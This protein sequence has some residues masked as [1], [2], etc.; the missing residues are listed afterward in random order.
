MSFDRAGPW[1]FYT[2]WEVSSPFLR[3]AFLLQ[4]FS[5][6]L[7]DV[8]DVIRAEFEIAAEAALSC[9]KSLYCRDIS[10]ICRVLICPLRSSFICFSSAAAQLFPDFSLQDSVKG[11][12]EVGIVTAAFRSASNHWPPL[13]ASLL[14]DLPV[15]VTQVV[16]AEVR[17]GWSAA[18]HGVTSSLGTRFARAS[19]CSGLSS[20]SSLILRFHLAISWLISPGLSGK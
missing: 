3:S 18:G 1:L 15:L 16:A 20:S 2:C 19:T 9:W 13:S 12:T 4:Q 10:S 17:R 5:L 11:H 7:H 14:L 6:T 8:L